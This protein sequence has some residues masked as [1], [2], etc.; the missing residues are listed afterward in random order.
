[1][2]QHHSPEDP[3]EREAVVR[4]LCLGPGRV[5]KGGSRTGQENPR[6]PSVLMKQMGAPEGRFPLR[7]VPQWKESAR[8][9]S[10]LCSPWWD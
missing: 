10:L 2:F 3:A 1:M 4:E 7:E 6:L 5:G 9:Q 8:L